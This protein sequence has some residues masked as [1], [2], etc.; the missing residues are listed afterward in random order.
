MIRRRNACNFVQI[1][2][3]IGGI[4][5]LVAWGANLRMGGLEQNGTRSHTKISKYCLTQLN[6]VLQMMMMRN[7]SKCDAT[8][9]LTTAHAVVVVVVVAG[10]QSAA[11][12]KIPSIPFFQ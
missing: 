2:N 3:Q 8:M 7:V 10:G 6:P 5:S 11:M 1:Y 4:F 9:L 12:A